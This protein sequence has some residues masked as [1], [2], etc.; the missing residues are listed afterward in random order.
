[1]SN[2]N[3]NGINTNYPVPGTNQS[4]QGFR[5]NFSAIVQNLNI[6]GT[7]IS[8]LQN[9]AVLKS[10]LANSVLNNDM[11]NTLI[12]NASTRSFRSTTYN[13]GNALAGTVQI[14]ASLGDVQYGTVANN[15][16]LQFTSW[17]PTGTQQTIELQLAISNNNATIS[18]PGSVVSSNNNYGTTILENYA[19]V[20]NVAT[21]T[22]PYGVTQLN[23]SI[24]TTDCGNTLYITPLNRPFD[25]TQL[26]TRTPPY[27][28]QPGDMMG[29]VASDANYLYVCTGNFNSNVAT[30]T[31]AN[32]YS[33]NSTL[34]V[35]S[36]THFSVNQPIVFTGNVFGGLTAN[37]VYYI[38]TVPT[39][40][41]LT[42]SNSFSGGSAG[43]TLSLT[44]GNANGV[45]RATTY[46]GGSNIW[47]RI[48]LDTS[49]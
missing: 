18:L 28:G 5:T 42:L 12:S 17:A 25:S 27:T 49:W 4:S 36:T 1:M 14:N 45:C 21:L 47:A 2:I 31:L 30:T 44:T 20:A 3:T 43:S 32:T 9:K 22:A 37:T 29:A 13:L 6:A 19:N 11:A 34:V 23:Y 33:G 10:A 48:S 35:T 7:E 26:L 8:D 15:V 41:T 46:Y 16:T 38:K 39:S 24:S 40:T